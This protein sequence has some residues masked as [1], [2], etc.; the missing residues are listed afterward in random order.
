MG[1]ISSFVDERNH[2]LR[3]Q[4]ERLKS[5]EET[6]FFSKKMRDPSKP[7]RPP[8]AYQIF[9]KENH[10]AMKTRNDELKSREI[11]SMLAKKWGDMGDKEKRVRRLPPYNSTQ[12]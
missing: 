4:L 7:K 8:T 6:R 12:T 2:L 11:F 5:C 9:T 10:L 3:D 1:L